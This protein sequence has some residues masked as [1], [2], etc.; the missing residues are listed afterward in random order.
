[1]FSPS[2]VGYFVF[3]GGGINGFAHI[4]VWRFLEDVWSANNLSLS[5]SVRGAAGASVGSI[6]ALAM[7]LGYSSHELEAFAVKALE[8]SKGMSKINIEGLYNGTSTGLM[9]WNMI[10]DFVR[11]I[12]KLKT[13]NSDLT[14]GELKDHCACEYVCTTHNIT[15]LRGEFFGTEH[16]PD[17]PVWKGV[18]M[19]CLHPILFDSMKHNGDEYYDGGLSNSLPLEVFNPEHTIASLITRTPGGEVTTLLGRFTRVVEAF[20]T[21]TKHKVEHYK[22]ELAA[23]ITVAI[24]VGTSQHL[25]S[26]GTLQVNDVKR[27]E[28]I[29]LGKIAAMH[30]LEHDLWLVVKA[31]KE[32]LKVRE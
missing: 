16:T 26:T 2:E 6:I 24:S 29:S 4:G 17:V 32:I 22:N 21:S 18:T 1:M 28:L 30:S 8:G 27:E 25:M 19:S 13:G 12:I 5:K 9:P 10:S 20:D 3:S 31:I 11:E 7:V 15:Q 23:I 14:F